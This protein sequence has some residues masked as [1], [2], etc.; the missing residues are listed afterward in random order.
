MLPRERVIAVI[1]HE[2]PDRQPIYGW[3]G[4][5]LGKEITAAFGSVA[6][7]EDQ[8][9]F[10]FA[11]LFGGPGPFPKLDAVRAANGG[12]VT[13][14]A[15]LDVKLNDPDQ[16][17]AYDNVRAAVK[18]HKTDRQ[19][20]V[21]MQ[22]PGIFECLNGAFGIEHHLEYLLTHPREL[23]VIYRRQAEWNR[24]FAMNCLDCGVDMIHIS[25]DW[26]GQH[27][28]LFSP[29]VWRELIYPNHKVT[30]DAVRARGAFL[31]LHSDGNNN[32]V[33]D[34]IAELGYQVFH[35]YQESAGMDYNVYRAKYADKF[36]LMGGLCIQTTLGFGQ[37]DRLKSEVERVL[38]LFANGGL[39]FCT[40]HF[41]QNHCTLDELRFAY[42]TIYRLVREQAR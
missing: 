24:R 25:D 1:R 13:P 30:C 22:T 29:R 32:A 31:S 7:F 41:V 36:V 34:G 6:A 18:H 33:L 4:A 27:G 35:P 15:M 17:A 23:A 11:H 5:N 19:R 40:T 21:Y 20:F 16:T 8:Y 26:G 2:R 10:D 9:E 37:Y 39:L 3:V 12:I 42:D 14:E 28:L 38:R